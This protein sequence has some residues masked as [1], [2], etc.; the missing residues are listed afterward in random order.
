MPRVYCSSH[1]ELKEKVFTAD[2]HPHSRAALVL[3]QRSLVPFCAYRGYQGW[4]RFRIELLTRWL[5]E[6]GELRCRYCDRGPLPIEGFSDRDVATLDHFIPRSLGGD[7]FD[8]SN[9]VVACFACNQRKRDMRPA[10]FMR[11]VGLQSASTQDTGHL[12]PSSG[13]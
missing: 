2:P 6:R 12:D 4:L 3:L 8:E 10:E 13:R 9:L 11:L 7:R 5:Q 1:T